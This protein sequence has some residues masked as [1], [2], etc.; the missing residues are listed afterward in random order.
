VVPTLEKGGKD[1][2][3]WKVQISIGMSIQEDNMQP[4]AAYVVIYLFSFLLRYIEHK[5]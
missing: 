4:T 5:N 3:L 1:S 2:L